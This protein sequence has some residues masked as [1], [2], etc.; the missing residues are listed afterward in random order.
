MTTNYHLLQLPAFFLLLVVVVLFAGLSAAITVL[1]R[2]C[3]MPAPRIK[4]S[5]TLGHIYGLVGGIY[6]LLI[7][8]VTV[9]VWGDYN[10]TQTNASKEESLATC[11]YREINY[12]PDTLKAQPLKTAYLQFVHSVVEREY[13]KMQRMEIFSE[14]D[15]EP[16][17]EVYRQFELLNTSDI[18]SDKMLAHLDELAL[19]RSLRLTGAQANIPTVIWIPLISGFLILLTC[20]LLLDI[21]SIRLHALMNSLLGAVTGLIVYIMLLINY[22]FSGS[23]RIE[24]TQYKIILQMEKTPS[25]P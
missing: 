1:Y 5:G 20:A 24:P 18:R 6:G 7:G 10:D 21:D 15:R 19:Y 14:V 2:R 17:D 12:F 25:S 4:Y 23:M 8:F 3:M 22:P 13:P 11:L 9:L 16:I